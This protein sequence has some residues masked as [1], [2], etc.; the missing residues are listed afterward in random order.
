MTYACLACEFEADSHVLKFY[1]LHDLV[2][3]IIGN[4][5]RRTPGR[6]L[7]V[8]FKIPYIYNSV[9]KLSKQQAEVIQNHENLMSTT[10]T[11]AK[12]NTQNTKGPN[13]VAVGHT[14]VQVSKP[15]L[16]LCVGCVRHN[17]LY[18]TRADRPDVYICVHFV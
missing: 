1:R 17:L 18:K 9:T 3:P 14:T 8:T 5:P 11:K 16:Y 2:F 13:L 10:Q 15:F 4:L 6:D 7:H 12:L